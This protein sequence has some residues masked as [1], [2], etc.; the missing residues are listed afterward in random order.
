MYIPFSCVRIEN[1]VFLGEYYRDLTVF[2]IFVIFYYTIIL[3]NKKLNLTF[4]Y[5]FH[6]FRLR[7]EY[8]ANYG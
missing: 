4:C 3:K 5:E 8:Y 7:N 1:N 2:I 6:L